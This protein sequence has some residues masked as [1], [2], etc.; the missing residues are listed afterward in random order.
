MHPKLVSCENVPDLPSYCSTYLER[1]PWSFKTFILFK[2]HLITSVQNCE[3]IQS[4]LRY[5]LRHYQC[6]N[7]DLKTAIERKNEVCAV[8]RGV[9][10]QKT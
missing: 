7:T 10:P 8:V 4:V 6:I 5:H 1:R 9:D 3:K 2:L